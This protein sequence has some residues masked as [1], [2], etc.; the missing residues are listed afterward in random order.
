MP[1]HSPRWGRSDA[2]L[3]EEAFG[4]LKRI[5]PSLTDDD[6]IDAAAGRL[7]FAQPVCPPGFLAMIPKVQTPIAGLQV[8]GTCISTPKTAA[9]RKAS[10]GASGW[11]RPSTT[12]R[13]E[14]RNAEPDW[15]FGSCWQ[16]DPPVLG[17]I[18]VAIVLC[19]MQRPRKSDLACLQRVT[20]RIASWFI[21]A[22]ASAKS[23]YRAVETPRRDR[24]RFRPPCRA[25]PP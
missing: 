22:H 9:F 7:R 16:S 1:S 10:G 6:R 2:D 5:N 18:A 19:A 23:C 11:P 25:P 15:Q 21:D 3:I 20:G 4:Y 12:P 13:S 8:V 14:L 24:N 17:T